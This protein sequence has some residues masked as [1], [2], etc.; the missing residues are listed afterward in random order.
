MTKA[1]FTQRDIQ[2]AVRGALKGGLSE[3][4]FVV[5]VTPAGTLRILPVAAA[6]AMDDDERELAEFRKAHGYG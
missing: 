4:G 2:N 5:E 1:A 6:P 3:G